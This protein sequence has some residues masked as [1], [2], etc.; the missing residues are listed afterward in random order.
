MGVVCSYCSRSS[1]VEAGSGPCDL[2]IVAGVC[3]R[4]RVSWWLVYCEE[5]HKSPEG[6]GRGEKATGLIHGKKKLKRKIAKA[7][8]ELRYQVGQWELLRR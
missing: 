2:P 5:V 6:G 8:W 4:G 1:Q 7:S 3:L